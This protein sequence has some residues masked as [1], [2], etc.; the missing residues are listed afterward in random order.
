MKLSIIGEMIYLMI[1]L[2]RIRHLSWRYDSTDTI[3]R[4]KQ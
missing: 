2:I 1:V 4:V 3:D